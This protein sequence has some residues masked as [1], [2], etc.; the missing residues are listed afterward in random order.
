M[1]EQLLRNFLEK[2]EKRDLTYKHQYGLQII[3]K[4]SLNL[5]LLLFEDSS[6]SNLDLIY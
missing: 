6:L 3:Y 1:N 2:F 5:L 4:I